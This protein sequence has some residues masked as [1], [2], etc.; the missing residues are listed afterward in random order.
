[1]ISYSIPKRQIKKVFSILVEGLKNILLYGENSNLNEKIGC[2][3]VVKTSSQIKV[4]FGNPINDKIQPVLATY[5]QTVDNLDKEQLKTKYI[6]TLET[7]FVKNVSES[8]VGLLIMAL[9]SDSGISYN[10]FKLDH[11]S[12][13]F[14]TEVSIHKFDNKIWMHMAKKK[15]KLNIV[16]STNPDFQFQF[17]EEEIIETLPKN[18]QKL[19]VSIDRKQRAGKEVTLIEGFVGTEEDLKELG[20]LLKSKCGVGGTVKDNEIMIQGNFRDKIVDLLMKDGY[21]VKKKG[22]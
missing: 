14:T 11:Q 7:T 1:M 10:F 6:E 20:K 12:F 5:I 21:S 4:L 13:L 8:G 18:Q 15:E 9:N 19:Y 17:E 3:L 2:V 16:Y 22:G